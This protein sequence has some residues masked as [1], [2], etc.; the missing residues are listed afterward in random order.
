MPPYCE[1]CCAHHGTDERHLDP[2]HTSGEWVAITGVIVLDPDGWDRTNFHE[3]WK[4]KI[5][6]AEFWCR[7]RVSTTDDTR[8]WMSRKDVA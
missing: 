7:A 2:L 6:R 1:T 4:Q 8:G 5:T 3:S